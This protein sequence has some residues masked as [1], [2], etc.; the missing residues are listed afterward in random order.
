MK[1]LITQSPPP[2]LYFFPLRTKYL[3][4]RLILKYPQLVVLLEVKD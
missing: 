1:L 4:Q 3:P 2:S